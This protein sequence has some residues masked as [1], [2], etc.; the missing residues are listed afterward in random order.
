MNQFPS[1][2]ENEVTPL[3]FA[4]FTSTKGTDENA[5][6]VRNERVRELFL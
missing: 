3:G 1:L 5:F 2:L 4:S 6:R